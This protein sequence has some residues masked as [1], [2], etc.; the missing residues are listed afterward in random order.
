MLPQ[1]EQ[2]NVTVEVNQLEES[3]WVKESNQWPV[4]QG[5][6]IRKGNSSD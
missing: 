5:A 3:E 2:K 6:A 1:L 4:E